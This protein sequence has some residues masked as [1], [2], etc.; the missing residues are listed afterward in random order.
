VPKYN[1]LP[2]QTQPTAAPAQSIYCLVILQHRVL[3]PGAASERHEFPDP[4]PVSGGVE[5]VFNANRYLIPWANV[6]ALRLR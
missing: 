3:L 1:K 2:Q 5:I 6:A 4:V